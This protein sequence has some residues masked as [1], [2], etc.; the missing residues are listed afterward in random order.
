MSSS[1]NDQRTSRVAAWVGTGGVLAAQG[2]LVRGMGGPAASGF[3]T[4]VGS[5]ARSGARQAFMAAPMPV[6]AASAVMMGAGLLASQP[7]QGASSAFSLAREHLGK[8][9]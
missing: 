4:G 2:A 6:K 5:M 3:Q 8:Y 7:I 9:F 1:S